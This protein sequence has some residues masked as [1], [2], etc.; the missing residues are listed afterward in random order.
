PSATSKTLPHIWFRHPGYNDSEN[1]L[2][3]LY[4]FD[5]GGVHHETARIPCCILANGPWDPVGNGNTRLPLGLDDI[6][7][8][9]TYYF[10]VPNGLSSIFRYL[11]LLGLLILLGGFQPWG[12]LT[13]AEHLP[14]ITCHAREAATSLLAHQCPSKQPTSFP[15]RSNSWATTMTYHYASIPAN[16]FSTHNPENLLRLRKDAYSGLWDVHRFVLFPKRG[17]WT[18]HVLYKWVTD[19]L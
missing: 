2:I 14:E 3:A 13:V 10:H 1:A 9:N 11:S 12:W 16:L 18:I 19:D 15:T 7:T 5:S 8:A 17:V 6:S 4:G